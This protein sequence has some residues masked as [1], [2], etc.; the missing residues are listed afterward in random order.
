MKAGQILNNSKN[1]RSTEKYFFTSLRFWRAYWYW[2]KTHHDTRTCCTEKSICHT[3]GFDILPSGRV[4]ITRS[5]E[6]KSTI[7]WIWA[8]LISY[9][10]ACH[11]NSHCKYKKLEWS[12]SM[13]INLVWGF[14]YFSI[15]LVT[16]HR[17]A[18]SSMITWAFSI[19]AILTSFLARKEP[20]PRL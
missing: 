13:I 4:E 3:P 19:C 7:E 6:S 16:G 10:S 8:A 20:E 18:P 12:F 17:P 2:T 9:T 11:E 5:T 15:S 14:L 1:I